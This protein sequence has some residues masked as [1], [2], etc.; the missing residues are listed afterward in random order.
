MPAAIA[1]PLIMAGA[2]AGTSLVAAKMGSNAA[3]NAAKTQQDTALGNVQRQQAASKDAMGFA[4]H[5]QDQA[6]AGAQPFI[7]M[8]HPAMQQLGQQ[9]GMPASAGQPAPWQP[10]GMSPQSPQ[11][12]GMFT[13]GQMPGQAPQGQSDMVRMRAP[14]GTERAVPRAQVQRYLQ[15]GA[16]VIA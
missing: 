9:F 12:G 11:W 13:G 2:S 6:N 16:Q 8:G 4:Q 10:V 15:R 14:N 7:G 3:K 1:I 5:Y